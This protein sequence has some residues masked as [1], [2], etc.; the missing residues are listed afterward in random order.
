VSD[1]DPAAAPAFSVVSGHP[2]DEEVAALVA[3]L[4]LRHTEV[5]APSQP[6]SGWSAYWRA[7]GAP[8]GPGPGAWQ[9]SSRR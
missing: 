2:T 7:V 1:V 5:E 3:A 6:V 9:A 4:T 8:L